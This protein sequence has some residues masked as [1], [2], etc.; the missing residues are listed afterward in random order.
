MFDDNDYVGD[1]PALSPRAP[2]TL[3]GHL[4]SPA[5]AVR[6]DIFHL[7]RMRRL[8]LRSMNGTFLQD[9]C[10]VQVP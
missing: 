9:R 1:C 3:H 4:L 5:I 6:A 8:H 2:G 10:R 7:A